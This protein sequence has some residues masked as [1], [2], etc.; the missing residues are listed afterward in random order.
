MKRINT[1]TALE[2]KSGMDIETLNELQFYNVMV[3]TDPH[4][5]CKVVVRD[6]LGHTITLGASQAVY[7]LEPRV[8]WWDK[9]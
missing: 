4:D 3:E 7:Q 5:A 6:N 9:D 8:S 2:I 1:L